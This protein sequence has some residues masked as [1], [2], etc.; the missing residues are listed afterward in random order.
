MV[1]FFN[2]IR[3]RAL[4]ESRF[5][6]YMVYA[7]GEIVLVVIGILIAVE[8]NNWNEERKLDLERN[9]IIASLI[10]DFKYNAD[11]IENDEI[12]WSDYQLSTMNLYFDLIE[13]EKQIVSTDSLRNLALRFM[14]HSNFSPNLSTY[15]KAQSS[16]KISLL[17]NK[18]LLNDIADYFE[19]YKSLN[20]FYE[21][22]VHAF[23]SGSTWE[24][25]KTLE[26]GLIYNTRWSGSTAKDSS[27]TNYRRIMT[28]VLARNAL[29]NAYMMEGNVNNLLRRLLKETNEILAT[30]EEMQSESK[31]ANR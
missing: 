15:N 21:E 1:R 29:Q 10:E 18:Q 11:K 30:L 13:Q 22:Q 5:A 31:K 6:R 16:G 2:R 12:K 9:E 25:R 24:F 3:V 19:V 23:Y 17:N 14:R 8:I 26:P 20:N 7:I 4:M 28:G 27:F